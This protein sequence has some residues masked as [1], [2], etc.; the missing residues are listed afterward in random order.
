MVVLVLLPPSG[1]TKPAMF[2]SL[3][4]YLEER[5]YI[6]VFNSTFLRIFI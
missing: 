5:Y 6:S 1:K 4:Q 3:I 2:I